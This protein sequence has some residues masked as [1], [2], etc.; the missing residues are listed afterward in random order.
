MSSEAGQPVEAVLD[1]E[2]PV[3][4][5]PVDTKSTDLPNVKEEHKDPLTTTLCTPGE[6]DN[7]NP[8]TGPAAVG[9]DTVHEQEPDV[10]I[11]PETS[12]THGVNPF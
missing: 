5:K 3:E 7:G 1:A 8:A 9:I 11:M 6:P 10:Y 2:K 12:R 4:E